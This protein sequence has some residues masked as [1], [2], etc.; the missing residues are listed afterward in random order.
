MNE[1]RVARPWQREAVEKAVE[2]RF[3]LN[4]SPGGSGKSLMQVMAATLDIERCGN[5]QLILVPQNHIHHGFFNKKSIRFQLES[6][7]E[8]RSWH[9]AHNFCSGKQS[10]KSDRL[11]TFLLSNPRALQ[12]TRS[13]GAI[14][15][16]QALVRV[17]G[18][19]SESEKRLAIKQLTVRIDEAHHISGVF[20]HTLDSNVTEKVLEVS[21]HLGEFC[22]YLV[23]QGDSSTKL[24]L[25]TATFFRG[26]KMP[27][28]FEGVKEQFERYRLPWDVFFEYL[29]L[30]EFR[31]DFF[32]YDDSPLDFVVEAIRLEPDARHLIILPPLNR[33]FRTDETLPTLMKKLADVV[34]E[35]AVLDLVSKETQEENK[36][37]ILTEPEQYRVVVACRLFDEGTDWVVCNRMHNTDACEASLTLAVQR[38]FR[39]CRKHDG[40]KSVRIMNYVPEISDSQDTETV[41][42]LLSDRFNAALACIVTSGELVPCVVPLKK[43]RE[44][45]GRKEETGRTL[46]DVYGQDVYVEIIEQLLSG[47]ECLSDKSD[48]SAVTEVVENIISERGIPAGVSKDAVLSTLQQMMLRIAKS[49][50]TTITKG[51]IQ[52]VG[53][54]AAAIAEAGFDKV[55]SRSGPFESAV[56]FGTDNITVETIR[57][58]CGVLRTIPSLGD[59]QASIKE[60]LLSTGK[61]PTYKTGWMA[62]IGRSSQ[63]V[64]KY[65]RRHY[66]STLAKEVDKVLGDENA[67]LLENAREVIQL[68]ADRGERLGNRWG[69]IPELGMSSFALNQRL[70]YHFG[71]TLAAEVEAICGPLSAEIDLDEV[72]EVVRRYFANGIKLGRKFG[73]IPELGISSY[74]LH[75][76]LARTHGV[77]LTEFVERTLGVSDNVTLEEVRRVLREYRRKGQSLVRGNMLIPEFG[78][79]TNALELRLRKLR[80]TLAKE[81]V[82]ADE[83]QAAQVVCSNSM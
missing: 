30:D 57:E 18:D 40:K 29:D 3:F 66:G 16:Q 50:S 7:G 2:A 68:Y 77:T 43:K 67:E 15:T 27:I 69:D 39:P 21:T 42:R 55:W 45:K 1:V 73:H 80:T 13:L 81:K 35:D 28:L 59:I 14:A 71:T 61:R 60:E 63:A 5:K 32:Q 25:T 64:E 22:R 58:L 79:T 11:K 48:A 83:E 72:A 4:E 52:E 82:T 31:F 53:F 74:G 36:R 38:I 20:D 24:H 70:Q 49:R 19:L 51:S 34:S 56:C 76:R 75:D 26:D 33:R 17:W 46:Q 41:R 10:A 47:Y 6:G 12:K 62:S 54:D 78:I 37:R 8:V 9:V 65:L 44:P 23:N